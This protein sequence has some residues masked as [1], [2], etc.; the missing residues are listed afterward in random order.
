[1]HNKLYICYN[2]KIGYIYCLRL[3]VSLHVQSLILIALYEYFVILVLMYLMNP[4]LITDAIEEDLTP[5]CIMNTNQ[6]HRSIIDIC[7]LE[8]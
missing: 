1:M 2:S 5:P 7:E 8:Y 6:L 3:I 4:R